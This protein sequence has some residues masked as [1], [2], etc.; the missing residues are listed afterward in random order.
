MRSHKHLKIV[1]TAIM[2]LTLI[3]NMTDPIL[4]HA[5]S[6]IRPGRNVSY[7][8]KSGETGDDVNA[9][10]SVGTG[11]D[12]NADKSGGT[13]D[14]SNADGEALPDDSKVVRVGW[15]DSTYN[16]LD[17]NGRRSGYA[18]EYQLKLSAYNGW[19]YEYVEGSW[20]DLLDMLENGEIDLMS[21]VS[22]TDERAEKMLYASLPMGTEEYYIFC[23][24]GNEELSSSD[25]STLNGKKVGVNKRSLQRELYL[26]WAEENNVDA[27]LVELS[28]S[29]EESLQMVEIGVL[30]AYVTVDSFLDNSR[31]MPLF[32][33]GSSDYYFVVSK[34]RPD[35]LEDLNYAMGM[36][37]DENRYFNQQMYE[38]YIR[39]AG[40]NAFLSQDEVKWLSEH[41]KIRV[42]YQDNYMAFCA[43]DEKTGRLTGVLKDYLDNLETCIPNTT[44]EFEEIAYPTAEA[45]MT[46]LKN[47]EVD[48]VFPANLS[49][50]EAEMDGMVMTPPI[51]DSEMYAIVRKMDTHIF[52][53]DTPLTAAVNEGN[54]NYDAFLDRNFPSW[55]RKYYKDTNDCLKAISKGEADCLIISNYRY[56]NIARRCEDYKLTAVSIGIEMDYCFAVRK[57]D[58]NLYSVLAKASTQVPDSSVHSAV[59]FYITEDARLSFTDFIEDNILIVLSIVAIIILVIVWLMILNMRAARMAKNLI[60]ATETDDLT[61]LYNRKF[62]FQYADRMYHEHPDVPMDAIVINIEQ[63]HSVNALYGRDLGDQVLQLLGSEIK[64]IA[65]ENSGIAGRFESDRF[66]IYCRGIEDYKVIFD[67]LQS[68]VD[69]FASKASIRLRMGVMPWRKDQ[70]PVQQ[71]DRARTACNMA[72]G[73]YKHR[74]IIYDESVSEREGYEQRLVNDLRHGLDSNEF[75]VYYQPKYD[76]QAD[77]PKLVSAEALV[78]WNHHEL[79]VISPEDF[80]SLFEKNGQIN[81]LD[82]YVWS[83]AANQI[84]H[85]REKYG[86]TVPISVNLSRVD[87]FDPNLEDT[88]EGILEKN[89]LDHSVFKL[90]VTESAYTENA[91]QVIHVVGDLRKKGYEVEMDDFGSGYSSLNMLSSMPID[92]LKMDRGFIQNIEHDEKDKL[93]VALILDI[94]KNLK[95]LVIAEGVE[96]ETQ[97]QLLKKLGCAIVQGYYFSKPLP[98]E[99][100]ERKYLEDKVLSDNK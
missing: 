70:E 83:E 90:E 38:K 30:D 98:A 32:K 21:D 39:R 53:Q 52:A 13:G 65:D 92:V 74:L 37:Q 2:L 26:E 23:K 34:A 41:G 36:I 49:G 72:R 81:M 82:K 22:Y 14:E 67:R 1:L 7:A 6:N 73:H 25:F 60:A 56:N 94:A 84:A 42:G 88:L 97:L 96:N 10:K 20:S 8:D 43:K 77:V 48:C 4:S 46:A 57:G 78:R 99:E 71:F 55:E 85:W 19:T 87:V 40:A 33:V 61:G 3:M 45:A 64:A 86:V 93:L 66:D 12:V 63:F 31:A 59:S 18:Y 15:Y 47:K 29:E 27:E 5:A 62:F 100:F 58:T 9:D 79:G 80:I 68:K 91:D 24:P 50:Y 54:T 69:D 44:L 16:S 75:E 95:V 17:E 11:D 89:Q 76:I 28:C 51:M 35:L